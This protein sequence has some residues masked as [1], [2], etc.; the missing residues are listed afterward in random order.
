MQRGKIS[1]IFEEYKEGFPGEVTE[2]FSI[3]FKIY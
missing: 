2:L 1:R 3:N